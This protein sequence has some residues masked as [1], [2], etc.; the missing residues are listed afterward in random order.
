[1]AKKDSQKKS[2]AN[3]EKLQ[4]ELT[5]KNADMI[6]SSIKMAYIMSRMSGIGPEGIMTSVVLAVSGFI[7]ALASAT[8]VSVEQIQK[9]LFGAIRDYVKEHRNDNSEA[10]DILGS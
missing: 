1:M 4:V 5:M 9:D 2:A 3:I 6:K 8:E 10:S 7:I